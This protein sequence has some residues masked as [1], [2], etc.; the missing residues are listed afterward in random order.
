MEVALSKRGQTFTL[1]KRNKEIREIDV[2]DCIDF[3]LKTKEKSRVYEL[4]G[5][6]N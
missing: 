4:R 3:K 2:S 5:N 1:D 6:K